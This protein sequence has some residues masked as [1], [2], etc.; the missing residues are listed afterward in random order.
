MFGQGLHE[1]AGRAV[2]AQGR[3]G[4]D[5]QDDAGVAADGVLGPDGVL[6]PIRVSELLL[7]AA[8]GGLVAEGGH[9]GS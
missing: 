1:P 5:V 3:V 8:V 2:A 9:G 6:V 7:E 4:F